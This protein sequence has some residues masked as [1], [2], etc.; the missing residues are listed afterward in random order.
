MDLRPAVHPGL[1]EKSLLLKSGIQ[2]FKNGDTEKPMIQNPTII[3]SPRRRH[4]SRKRRAVEGRAQLDVLMS[5][6]SRRERLRSVATSESE[7]GQT[8]QTRTGP[9]FPGLGVRVGIQLGLGCQ[10]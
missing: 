10:S 9:G 4:T 8:T 7:A 2:P 6:P 5:L 3:I 1:F